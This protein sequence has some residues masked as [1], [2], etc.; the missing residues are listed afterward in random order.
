MQKQWTAVDDYIN[1]SLIGNDP[2]LDA[3]L[4]DSDAGG[5]PA[6]SVTAAQGKL[7][8]LLAKAQDAKQILEIGTLGGYSAIWMARALPPDGKLVTLEINEH[9]AEV[10]RKNIER[11]GLQNVVDVRVGKALDTL[12]ALHGPFDLFFIDADKPNIPEYFEWAVKLS[13]AGS[14]IVVDNVVR[15]GALADEHSDDVNVQGVR[16]LHAMLSN[17]KRVTATTI[18]TVGSKGYDGFTLAVVLNP[19]APARP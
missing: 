9:H 2:I 15:N 6:I 10:A 14:V 5:L 11:A 16:R 12:A 18:Q 3:A 19:A 17:D 13:R 7:L 1:E 4:V 8:Q